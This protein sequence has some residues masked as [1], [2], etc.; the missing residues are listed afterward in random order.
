MEIVTK[1]RIH[2]DEK[3]EHMRRHVFTQVLSVHFRLY[4]SGF[5]KECE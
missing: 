5:K 2:G 3:H 1:I 4:A